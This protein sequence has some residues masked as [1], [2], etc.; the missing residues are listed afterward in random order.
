MANVA[1]NQPRIAEFPENK[2]S[3]IILCKTIDGFIANSKLITA[4]TVKYFHFRMIYMIE[5]H[6]GFSLTALKIG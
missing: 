1:F 3:L 6:G 2:A 5:R 4:I